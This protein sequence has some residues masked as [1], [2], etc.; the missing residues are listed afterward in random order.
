M[1]STTLV[2]HGEEAVSM[3]FLVALA[4][5]ETGHKEVLSLRGSAEESKEGWRLLLED[6]RARGVQQIGLFLTDGN[7]G[8]LAALAEVFPATARQR[9]LLHVQR[10]VTSAISKG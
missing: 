1:G 4:V 8:V 6:L 9:C 7:D 2:R 10:S 3:P 5:D